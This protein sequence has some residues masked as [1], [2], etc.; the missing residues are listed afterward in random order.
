M[1]GNR[2]VGVMDNPKYPEC[3]RMAAVQSEADLLSGF[4]DWLH[5][6]QNIRLCIPHKHQGCKKI[7]CGFYQDELQPDPR[8]NEQLLAD[9]FKIDLQ[10]VAVERTAMLEAARSQAQIIVEAERERDARRLET[11]ELR[12]K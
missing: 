11:M 2:E 1:T 12:E 9:Y 3:E 10:K 5:Y 8:S 7:E 6:E 4:L